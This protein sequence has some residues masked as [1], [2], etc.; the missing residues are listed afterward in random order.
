[1]NN[2]VLKIISSDVSNNFIETV[3]SKDEFDFIMEKIIPYF[4]LEEI[5]I[6]NIM[7]LPKDTVLSVD[8]VEHIFKKEKS[9]YLEN[10]YTA[11]KLKEFED[12]YKDKMSSDGYTDIIK[13]LIEKYLPIQ[14]ASTLRR[15][16]ELGV[17]KLEIDHNVP[18]YTLLQIKNQ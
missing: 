14:I 16:A 12:K 3:F 15:L 18:R 11:R 7:N 8:D 13:W 17:V 6:N 10:V 5:I 4:Y 9:R 1:M 2:T